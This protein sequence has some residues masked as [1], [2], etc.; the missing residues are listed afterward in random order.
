MSFDRQM[1]SVY[2]RKIKDLKTFR[3]DSDYKDVEII[4]GQGEKAFQIAG[5]IRTILTEN[6]HL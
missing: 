3:I 6:L 5:E 1:Y 2:N 4:S